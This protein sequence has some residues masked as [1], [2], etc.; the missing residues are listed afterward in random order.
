MAGSKIDYFK[1]FIEE[2]CGK[3]GGAQDSNITKEELKGLKSLK[4]R[5]ENAGLVVVPTNKTGNFAVMSRVMYEMIGRAHTRGDV[6]V[7]WDKLGKSKIELNGTK[8]I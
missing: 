4:T 3:G 6:V 2:E 8:N 1:K 7:G 5:I